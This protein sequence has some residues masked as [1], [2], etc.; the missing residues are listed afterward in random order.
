[1]LNERGLPQMKFEEWLMNTEPKA[2]IFL[3]KRGFEDSSQ[4]IDTKYNQYFDEEINSRRNVPS[5]YGDVN[6]VLS[7][8]KKSGRKN[9]ILSS[10]REKFL[11]R[12]MDEYKTTRF[13]DHVGENASNKI[14]RIFFLCDLAEEKPQNCLYI[15]DLP[16]CIVAA[17]KAGVHTAGITT[18]YGKRQ[19]IERE[20]PEYILNSLSDLKDVFK[21]Q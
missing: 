9:A 20:N 17:K 6:D 7:H 1:M 12:M 11:M 21:I 3:K 10:Y 16:D 15:D 19:E 14:E 5:L 13:L 4:D 2:S 8:L 18:G